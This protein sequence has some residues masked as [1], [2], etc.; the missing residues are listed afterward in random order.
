LHPQPYQSHRPVHGRPFFH[1]NGHSD[2]LLCWSLL[3]S[4][5]PP[6]ISHTV[7]EPSSRDVSW[8][9]G[10]KRIL[11]SYPNIVPVSLRF[12]TQLIV[13]LSLVS[14]MYSGRPNCHH[15]VLVPANTSRPVGA[16]VASSANRGCLNLPGDQ[17]WLVPVWIQMMV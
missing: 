16:L 2:H 4:S 7:S 5:M 17:S 14:T 12:P 3:V 10:S 8:K 13:A 9:L 1:G 11:K 15:P 6:L